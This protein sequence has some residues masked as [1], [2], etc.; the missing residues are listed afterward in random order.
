MS[1]C[2]CVCVS[3]CEMFLM[4]ELT[5]G[6]HPAAD[7]ADPAP[8]GAQNGSHEALD[9]DVQ[10]KDDGDEHKD[11]D[12]DAGLG[13]ESHRELRGLEDGDDGQGVEGDGLRQVLQGVLEGQDGNVD[14]GDDN[15]GKAQPEG[16]SLLVVEERHVQ[17]DQ[18]R[19]P[20]QEHRLPEEPRATVA[21]V[22]DASTEASAERR[23]KKDGGGGNIV[24]QYGAA[25]AKRER[26]RERENKGQT[27][28]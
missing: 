4:M 16:A 13:L 3:S 27:A 11:G 21:H 26:E 15:T 25:S 8:K 19:A 28:W 5:L 20:R 7:T 10:D 12:E 23:G 9:H 22:K 17:P 14:G 18:Q 2:V 6:I 24:R 1:V